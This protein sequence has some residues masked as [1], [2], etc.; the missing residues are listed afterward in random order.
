MGVGHYLAGI[1][2]G[3]REYG[4]AADALEAYLKLAPQAPTPNE[5][6]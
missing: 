6:A 2:W 5:P 3:R 1:Y 4:R